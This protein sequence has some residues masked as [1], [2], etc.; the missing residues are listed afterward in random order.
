MEE[1][2]C[3]SSES[4]S[5]LPF[6]LFLAGQNVLTWPPLGSLFYY[7]RKYYLFKE[8]IIIIPL[9]FAFSVIRNSG[10]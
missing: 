8:K 6:L 10:F 2:F 7:D 5:V 4:L 1:F 9:L 3:G